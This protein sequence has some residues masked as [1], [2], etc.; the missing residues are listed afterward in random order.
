MI[1]RLALLCA[2]CLLTTLHARAVEESDAFRDTYHLDHYLVRLDGTI[3]SQDCAIYVDEDETV[4]IASSDLDAWGLKRPRM[5]AFERDGRAYFNLENDLRLAGSLDGRSGELDIVAPQ[6]AFRGNRG[7]NPLPLNYGQGAFLNY[8]LTR[9]NGRYDLFAAGQGGIYEMRYLSTAGSGGLE[10]HR[11]RLRWYR[12]NSNSHTVI[13]IGDNT[14]DGGWLGVSAPFAGLHYATDYTGDPQYVPHGPPSV[15][16]FANSP[17]LLEIYVDNVLEL[18]TDVPSG[19]FH[20]SDLPSSAAHSDI[21]MVL[22]DASGKQT[23]QVAR[24]SYDPQFLGRGLSQFR[25]DAGVAH[26]NL[27]SRGQ[28]YRGLV[29]QSGLEYGIT[30]DVTAAFLGESISGE[31]FFDGGADVRVSHIHQFGFRIGAGNRRRSSEYRYEVRSGNLSFRE[32]FT[33]N[34]L[35][36]EPIPETFDGDVVAQIAESSSL[37]L[38]MGDAWTLGMALSRSRS[39]SGSN[40]SAISTRTSYRIGALSFEVAPFYDFISRRINAD[41]SVN[42]RLDDRNSVATNA[43]V[44]PQGDTT[45][46]LSWSQDDIGT[47]NQLSTTVNVSASAS[48]ERGIE[49]NDQLPWADARMSWQQQNGISI[50]EP[51]LQGGLAFLGGNLYA[52]RR[53]D[54][55]ESFGIL[56]IPGLR[57]VRVKVNNSDVGATNSR[58]EVLLRN[59][60][61]YTENDIDIE[62]VPISYNIVDPL[63]VVPGKTSPMVLTVRVVSRGGVTLTAVDERGSPLP[64][65]SWL[66]GA[67]RYPI[68]YGGR[69]FIPALLPGTHLL[70]SATALGERCTIVLRVPANVDDIPDLGA[71]HCARGDNA[72]PQEAAGGVPQ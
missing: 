68:G 37:D 58:G 25:F 61:P 23:V 64:A 29:E 1:R 18:R 3:V 69:V 67:A 53:V 33:Y 66:Q 60:R 27:D 28:Y 36:S 5:P 30:D 34:S 52:V 44:T 55:H 70:R 32:D 50:Y 62:D 57:N 63:R 38:R 31:D 22:T 35:R 9:E 7:A 24:P 59:L 10:F 4:Y 51:S 17:S 42:F 14:S 6:S 43:A 21:V 26:A 46:R 71:Q 11:S 48:Q 16:G 2:L 47:N 49:L 54:E 40:Q 56:R 20:V 45:A 8:T 15:S 13:S 65:G 12:L 19:A 41:A 39:S 72:R